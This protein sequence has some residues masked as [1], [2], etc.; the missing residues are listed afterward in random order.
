MLGLGGKVPETED[1]KMMLPLRAYGLQVMS[2]GALVGADQ[3]MVW[4]GPMVTSA[5]NQLRRARR[6]LAVVTDASGRMLGIVTFTDLLRELI[7][8][9]PLEEASAR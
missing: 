2:M 7:G 4:R 3:P 5:L 9:V 1:G 8:D 6:E